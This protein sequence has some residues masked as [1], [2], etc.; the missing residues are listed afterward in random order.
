MC[1]PL[2]VTLGIL[3]SSLVN[4][5]SPEGMKTETAVQWKN[6]GDQ[7]KRNRSRIDG[8]SEKLTKKKHIPGHPSFNGSK[9]RT[10]HYRHLLRGW[11]LINER[12]AEPTEAEKEAL[13]NPQRI[14]QLRV[15]PWTS[16]ECRISA[17][18]TQPNKSAYLL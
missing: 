10:S 4:H 3:I 8:W 1:E 14:N 17:Y 18:P 5:C 13:E 6:L 11:E 7:L 2:C 15:R 16:G 12:G 9:Y